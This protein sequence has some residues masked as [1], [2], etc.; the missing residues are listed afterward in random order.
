MQCILAFSMKRSRTQIWNVPL[1]LRDV[2]STRR[3]RL[4]D[5]LLEK[6]LLLSATRNSC[7]IQVNKYAIGDPQQLFFITIQL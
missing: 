7:N 6:Y 4:G 2:V 5:E 1:V 3:H